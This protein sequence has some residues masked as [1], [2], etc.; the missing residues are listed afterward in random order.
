MKSKFAVFILVIIVYGA[1]IF[2][3]PVSNGV[4]ASGGLSI[5]N[6]SDDKSQAESSLYPNTLILDLKLFP[7]LAHSDNG[8]ASFT[9]LDQQN[10]AEINPNLRYNDNGIDALPEYAVGITPPSNNIL[11]LRFH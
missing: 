1:W 9:M 11:E 8:I 6:I 4:F 7:G 2:F 5:D 3:G 10:Y